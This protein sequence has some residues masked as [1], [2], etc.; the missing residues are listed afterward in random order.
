MI[1]I[2]MKIV[3]Y[4]VKKLSTSQLRFFEYITDLTHIILKINEDQS[5]KF[6][7]IQTKIS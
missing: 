7:I 2:I 1:I 3:I 6:I 5:P 4:K